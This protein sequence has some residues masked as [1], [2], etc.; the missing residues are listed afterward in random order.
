MTT[1]IIQGINK[2]LEDNMENIKNNIF[3]T[4][5]MCKVSF[6]KILN[7]ILQENY[8]YKNSINPKILEKIK[9]EYDNIKCLC[10]LLYQYKQWIHCDKLQLSK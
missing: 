3:I 8:I 1:S 9:N 5:S 4:Y 10:E 7:E 2:I 6:E